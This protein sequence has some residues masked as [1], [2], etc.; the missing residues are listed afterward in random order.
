MDPKEEVFQSAKRMV[1]NQ[2]SIKDAFKGLATEIKEKWNSNLIAGDI[3]EYPQRA[4]PMR[5]RLIFRSSDDIKRL[6]KS[7]GE[8][9]KKIGEVYKRLSKA[10][11]TQ[12]DVNH[13]LSTLDVDYYSFEELAFQ[14]C[15]NRIDTNMIRSEFAEQNIW[16]IEK[17]WK[18]FTVFYDTNREVQVNGRRG[19]SDKIQ[20]RFQELAKNEDQFSILDKKVI[21]VH[22]DSKENYERA[23]GT[24]KY[25][26]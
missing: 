10:S 6:P 15:V 19:I 9:Q 16:S 3:Y 2:E 22:F 13:N 8:R 23:G 12:I 5:L 14:E 24:I 1:L 4:N 7:L 26:R 17:N 21:G 11:N 20:S 18:Y 25:Y